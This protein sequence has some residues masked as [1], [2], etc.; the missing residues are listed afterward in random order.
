MITISIELNDAVKAGIKNA[1]GKKYLNAVVTELKEADKYGNTHTIYLSQ[2]K[3]E[4]EAKAA[5]V[6]IGKGK[7]YGNGPQPPKQ[8]INTGSG[9]DDLPF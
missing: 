9:A 4:R 5:K 7:Q 8:N 3:D 2:S 6:Y 1:N